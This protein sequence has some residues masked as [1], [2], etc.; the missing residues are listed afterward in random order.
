MGS[1]GDRCYL[2]VRLATIPTPNNLLSILM[3]G[4]VNFRPGSKGSLRI[5]AVNLQNL[6]APLGLG[7]ILAKK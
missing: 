2:K 6:T 4:I 1:G 7:A 5:S 3:M